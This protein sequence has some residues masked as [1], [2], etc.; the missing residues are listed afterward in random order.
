MSLRFFTDQCVP[1][2][3][4][5]SLGQAGHEVLL[6]KE[7]LPIGSDDPVV[8]AESQKL[9][10]ILVSLNGDFSD[11]VTYPPSLYKGIISL[12]V[13]N[14]PEAFPSITQRLMN[15]LSGHPNM[16]DYNGRLLLVQPHRIRIRR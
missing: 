14:H 8:I 2:S 6:L 12:Q 11:I 7:H 9:S 1:K 16:V 3:V 15:Y 10:A 4:T 5:E 13:R